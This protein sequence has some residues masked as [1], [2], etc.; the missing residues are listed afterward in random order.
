MNHPRWGR[1]KRIKQLVLACLVV[2]LV[3]VL[4]EAR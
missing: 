2:A 1:R 4:L 3:T